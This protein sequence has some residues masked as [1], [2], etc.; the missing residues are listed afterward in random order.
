MKKKTSNRVSVGPL[1]EGGEL[2]TDNEKMAEMLNSW[3]CSVF[4]RENLQELPEAEKIFTGNNPLVSV[5]FTPEI[6]L[7]K[8]KKLNP[9]SAP[10]PDGIWTRVIHTMADVICGPLSIIYSKCLEEGGVPQE[11]KT[12]NVAPIYKKGPKS[13]PGNYQPVSL[14]CV[15]CKTMEMIIC[16]AII[17]HLKEYDLIRRSQHGFMRGRSTLT[18]LLM[19]LEELTKL[20]DEGHSLDLVYLDFSK[21]FDKVPIQRLMNKCFGLGIQGKLH[22]WIEKWLNGRKQRVVLNGKASSWGDI[23]SGVVQ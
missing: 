19:Y 9:D 20:I 3:Y 2:V 1:K 7:K 11:W 18:N 22:D 13:V 21:A 6:V 4:T 16:D 5:Q 10:G 8:L 14:T 23:C 12:A 17:E 15:L